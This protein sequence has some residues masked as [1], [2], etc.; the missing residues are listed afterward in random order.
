VV[1]RWGERKQGDFRLDSDHQTACGGI[2]QEGR[3]VL[4]A[5]RCCVSGARCR[6]AT[7]AAVPCGFLF[8]KTLV[9]W[10]VTYSTMATDEAAQAGPLGV[11]GPGS[12]DGAGFRSFAGGDR[13]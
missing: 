2:A 7:P 8:A 6:E 13:R 10:I 12:A 3:A 9:A 1:S 11:V 4:R 5:G